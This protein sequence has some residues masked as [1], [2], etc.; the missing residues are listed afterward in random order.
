MTTTMVTTTTTE[1]T[2]DA[3]S[4][5]EKKQREQQQQQK[6]QRVA[7]DVICDST[8]AMCI[9]KKC[10]QAWY[11]TRQCAK[12]AAVSE[13]KKRCE[14]SIQVQTSK[15]RQ[16][17][18]R[19]SQCLQDERCGID[20]RLLR[21]IVRVH[22]Y[23]PRLVYKSVVGRDVDVTWNKEETV[24][25]LASAWKIICNVL[26]KGEEKKKKGKTIESP[27]RESR[28]SNE[29][30]PRNKIPPCTEDKDSKTPLGGSS[31]S[32]SLSSSFFLEPR[33]YDRFEFVF[34]HVSPSLTTSL[35]PTSSLSTS[36][37][38]S[39]TLTRFRKVPA[40]RNPSSSRSS[41][42]TKT[43]SSSS[44]SSSHQ[45]CLTIVRKEASV[46]NP[47]IFVIDSTCTARLRFPI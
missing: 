32:S 37:S 35:S 47:T 36:S 20:W 31:S 10:R 15:A 12:E 5:V 23:K 40:K 13:H 34:V 33:V 3:S 2:A 11:C 45:M 17:F 19:I 44:S 24:N 25:A 39:T 7:C 1:I 27:C 46:T 43:L 38:K 41:S 21:E 29:A 9:C 22:G 16:Q 18:S 30:P 26:T 42:T 28:S 6:C 14:V 8:S 4:G